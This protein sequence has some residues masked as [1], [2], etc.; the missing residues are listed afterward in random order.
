[1]AFLNGKRTGR[2]SFRMKK[3]F[4]LLVLFAL[5]AGSVNGGITIVRSSG[6]ALTGADGVSYVGTSGIALTGADGFLNYR[7]DGITLTG[8]DGITPTVG[9]GATYVGPNGI[10]LT[11]A[12]GITL[13]GADGITL[14]GADDNTGLQSVDPELAVTLNNATDDSNINA[15]IV[16]HTS[17][18]DADIT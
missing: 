2:S 10:T 3:A 6:I 14:T 12:D 5:A 4:S 13:T 18:T 7:A 9:N 15:V 11:G 8:A 17:V 1:M 16:Y